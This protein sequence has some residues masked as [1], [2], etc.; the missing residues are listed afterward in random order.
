LAARRGLNRLAWVAETLRA[1]L[2]ALATVAPDWLQGLVPLAWYERYGKRLEET[3]LPQG[4][5]KRDAYAQLVGEDGF[6]LLDALEAPETPAGLRALPS[7][8]TL[9]QAWQRHDDRA[10]DEGTRQGSPAVAHVRF[11]PN[12]E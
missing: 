7:M 3:R 4:Q 1:A 10:T 11:K 8:A 9:R 5:A 12:R 2:N 6:W